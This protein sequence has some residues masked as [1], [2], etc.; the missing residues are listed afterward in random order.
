VIRDLMLRL[1]ITLPLALPAM[2]VSSCLVLRTRLTGCS[3][4]LLVT[5]IAGVGVGS[6][7]IAGVL[8]RVFPAHQDLILGTALSGIVMGVIFGGVAGI[9]RNERQERA[10]DEVRVHAGGAEEIGPQS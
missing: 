8:G 5:A 2:W 10:R 3:A 6:G 7:L 4:Y 1:A 9:G